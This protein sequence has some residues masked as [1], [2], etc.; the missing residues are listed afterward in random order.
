MSPSPQPVALRNARIVLP[1][2][3]V[4][5]SVCVQDGVITSIDPGQGSVGEDCEGA[6]LLPGLIEL[7][8]DNLERHIR[9]RPAV[10]WPGPAAVLA[11]DG[12]LASV[13]I[14]TV[15]DAIRVG[16]RD[17]PHTSLESKRYA[18]PV[19]DALTQLRTARALRID[20]FLHLRC[21]VSAASVLE[22]LDEFG[23]DPLVRL[24]SLMDHTPGQRQYRDIDRFREH[25]RGRHGLSGPPLEAF[26]E[27]AI[28]DAAHF[29]AP[30]ETGVAARARK[31]RAVIGSHDD[32]TPA[33][34]ARSAELGV[35][36]AEFPTTVEAARALNEQGIPVM[37]GAPNLLRGGSHSGNVAA[38]T[39]A[40]AGL[41]DI[42]SSDY[43]PSALLTG[44][45]RLGDLTGDLPAAVSTVTR[46]P[47]R[48]A[49]LDDR[50]EIAEGMRADLVLVHEAAE[51]AV[52][53]QV[54]AAGR[55]V[56]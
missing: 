2:E 35:G 4:T 46:T 43:V 34:V 45:L 48:V 18:R 28:A 30:N 24:V 55:V 19:A 56:A 49:G 31:M 5:G 27:A 33:H 11:H 29:C 9:P 23:E 32:T 42:L 17:L 47:A 14:T 13:G 26:I 50:G 12:E 44:A 6:L 20:H 22:E 16:R 37:M 25:Y 52:V 53:R 39:L 7:H 38:A 1:H 51:C 15:F 36:F 41:V 10:V 21:E 3:V 8:T 54:W 40:D